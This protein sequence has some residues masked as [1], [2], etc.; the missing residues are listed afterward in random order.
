MSHT[1]TMLISIIVIVMMVCG[2]VA[3]VDNC[4]RRREKK[5]EDRIKKKA[6]DAYISVYPSSRGMYCV[7][8]KDDVG[9]LQKVNK[10]ICRQCLVT[11][12]FIRI[13]NLNL[14]ED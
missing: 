12:A 7:W 14:I 5:I 2:I 9:V 3:L 11:K 13:L 8:K 6:V 4:L 10:D 1:G